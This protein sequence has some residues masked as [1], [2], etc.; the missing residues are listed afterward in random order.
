M[1]NANIIQN[2]LTKNFIIT[3]CHIHD[4]SPC[5]QIFLFAFLR[6]KEKVIGTFM[7]AI[8]FL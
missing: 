7:L 1:F 6:G 5:I 2:K 8:Y 3:S 4:G